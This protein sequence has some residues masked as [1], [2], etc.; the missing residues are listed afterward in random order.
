M[1]YDWCIGSASTQTFQETM[2]DRPPAN[3]HTDMGVK[4]PTW[5]ERLENV[6]I[7]L[8]ENSYY[9]VIQFDIFLSEFSLY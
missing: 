4:L 5:Y 9:P 3:H 1:C 7:N 8:N 6:C 2:T